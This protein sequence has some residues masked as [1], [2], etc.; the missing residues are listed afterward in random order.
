MKD[1]GKTRNLGL[2]C[3]AWTAV[4]QYKSYSSQF[5]SPVFISC[6]VACL[7]DEA[8]GRLVMGKEPQLQY[9]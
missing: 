5:Y 3:L 8:L 7:G 2:S 1:L 4:D 9:Q 6:T